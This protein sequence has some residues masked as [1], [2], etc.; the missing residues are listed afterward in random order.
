M[1]YDIENLE[2]YINKEHEETTRS[3]HKSRVAFIIKNNKVNYLRESGYSHYEWAK[4][5]GIPDEE[6]NM[7]I[8][9]YYLDGNI[10]FYRDNFIYDDNVI[11]TA[12]K[13]S[14]EIKAECSP[15]SPCNIYC[16]L[17]VGKV[18][19]KWPVDLFIEAI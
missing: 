7:L 16:G 3:F 14:K 18:G 1:A 13:F 8:R 9:G 15:N 12:K 11:A 5:M 4:E 10:V 2:N 6:F 17:K 19:E